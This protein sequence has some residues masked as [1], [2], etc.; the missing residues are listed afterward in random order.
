MK[1][2][3]TLIAVAAMAL[4]ANAQQFY[5]IGNAPLG[6]EWAAGPTVPMELAEDGVTNTITVEITA[7]KWFALTDLAEFDGDWG[8][9]NANHRF[10]VWPK[11]EEEAHGVDGGDPQPVLV[12]GS[13]WDIIKCN[14]PTMTIMPGKWKIT[15]N[16]STMKLKVEGVEIIDEVMTIVGD[17]KVFG[18][19]WDPA[20]ENNTMTDNG[21]GTYTLELKGIELE[22]GTYAYKSVWAHSWANEY[23][24]GSGNDW[25]FEIAEA[26]VYD[27]TF[28]LTDNGDNTRSCEVSVVPATDGIATVA[29]EKN[30]KNVYYNI[31]GQRVNANTKGVVIANGKKLVRK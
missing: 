30:V 25:T 5:L 23:P 20:D 3:F 27:L 6:N 15:F 10:G 24:S 12:D 17:P 31:A 28:T 4:T 18:T 29:A 16:A 9:L 14:E 21:D 11:S 8:N 19:N 2:I 1:K 7:Q 22:A 13:E 26:G